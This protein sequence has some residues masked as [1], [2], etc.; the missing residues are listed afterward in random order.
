MVSLLIGIRFS[1]VT[2][3]VKPVLSGRRLVLTYNLIHESLGSKELSANS[4]TTM[5]KLRLLLPAWIKNLD[6]GEEM[7]TSLAF[8]FEHQYTDASLCYDGLKGHDHQVASHLREA[9]TEFGVCFYLANLDKTISGGCDDEYGDYGGYGGYAMSGDVHEIIDETD[10]ETSLKRVV[11]LDGTEVAQGLEFDEESFI[12]LAP[13]ED[14]DPDDED[15]S[16]FTGNEGVST[17]HFYHRT[18][19]FTVISRSTPK[20]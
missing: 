2:H 7:P 14:E 5:A 20:C 1:D 4:N 16:G 9:C 15:Y 18:V 11:E 8:L 12:Q 3:E 17:T 10:R 13:L 19:R 6:A